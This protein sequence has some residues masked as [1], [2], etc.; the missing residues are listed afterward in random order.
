[1]RFDNKTCGENLT[2]APHHSDALVGSLGG[3]TSQDNA[4]VL[5]IS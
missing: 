3:S 4:R 1:M 5:P 2:R